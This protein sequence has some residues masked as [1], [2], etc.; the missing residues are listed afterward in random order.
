MNREASDWWRP[1]VRIRAFP[2]PWDERVRILVTRHEQGKPRQVAALQFVDVP[3]G[4]P[5]D[6]AAELD[7]DEAQELMDTLWACGLRP[8]QGKQSEGQVAAIERH[9]ADMRAIAFA[10]LEIKQP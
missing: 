3:E 7:H 4:G 1:Y 5:V 2:N 9:L 10:K 6:G 8:T